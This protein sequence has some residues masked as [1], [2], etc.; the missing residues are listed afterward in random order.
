MPWTEYFP[1]RCSTDSLECVPLLVEALSNPPQAFYCRDESG[2]IGFAE[3]RGRIAAIQSWL[4][5]RGVRRGDRI[6]VMLPNSLPHVALILALMLERIVWV[7]VN[8]RLK[9]PGVTH[10]IEHSSPT[11]F[12]TDD[13]DIADAMRPLVRTFDTEVLQQG[14]LDGP[15][16]VASGSPSDLFSIIYT[17]GTTGA[18]KGVEFT[19][20][21]L[22]IATEAVL[23]VADVRPGDRMIV[24][25][26]LCH[27][28]GAQLLM[29]PVLTR[30]QLHFVDRFSASGFLAC[31]SAH[32]ITHAHYLGGVLDFLSK[33]PIDGLDLQSLRVFWGAGATQASWDYVER[34]FGA[35]LRECYGMTECSSFAT[36]N[37]DGTPM[38]IGKPLPWIRLSL[39]GPDGSEVS[40]GSDGEIV[41][42]SAVDG[43]F[44]TGYH[45]DPEASARALRG[46]RLHTGDLARRRDGRL[47]FVG[48]K[49]DSMRV[50][51]ENVSAWEVERV[52]ASHP[53]IQQVAAVGVPS[54]SGEQDILLFVKPSSGSRIDLGRLHAWCSELLAPYQVPRYYRLVDSFALTPSERIRKQLLPRSLEGAFDARAGS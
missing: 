50:R 24:W 32:A 10:I 33:A 2:E 11:A 54:P 45:R 23:I 16:H 38:S 53:G 25:E 46:G 39:L 8:T 14:R 44:M 30:V 3:L 40:D 36:V 1:R 21:M 29:L 27:V 37:D 28:G 4:R 51:G 12:I 17:S 42:E 20:R 48:R 31:A 6:A 35:K 15:V 43:A 41:L 5:T 7:P 19:H 18:P 13:P 26:P 49:S 47:Y 52:F 22:R 9:T 34:V